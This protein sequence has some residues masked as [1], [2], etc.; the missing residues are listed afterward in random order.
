MSLVVDA[1][2]LMREIRELRDRQ[3]RACESD[4]AAIDREYESDLR[5]LR[6]ARIKRA[7]LLAALASTS[8]VL[9]A[10]FLSLS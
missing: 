5:R 1:D 6:R 8:L 4:L 2:N 10:C 7:A 9:W 3:R